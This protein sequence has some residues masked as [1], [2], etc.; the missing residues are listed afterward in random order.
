MHIKIMSEFHLQF[1]FVCM[2]SN[3]LNTTNLSSIANNV[4]IWDGI[5]GLGSPFYI[6][7]ADRMPGLM[8]TET[9]TVSNMVNY[10]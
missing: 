10:F 4:I 5:G 2:V 8:H 9:T 3:D 1:V 6:C 7:D